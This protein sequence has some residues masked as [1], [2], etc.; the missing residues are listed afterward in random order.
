LSLDRL[1]SLFL[2]IV[3]ERGGKDTADQIEEALTPA[4]KVNPVTGVPYAWGIDDELDGLDLLLT[5]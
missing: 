3:I 5:S 4:N 1:L 2:A